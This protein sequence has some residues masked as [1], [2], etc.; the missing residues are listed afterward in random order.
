M[1][2]WRDQLT[3]TAISD[4]WE[5]DTSRGFSVGGSRI[6]INFPVAVYSNGSKGDFVSIE[7]ATVVEINENGSE[8]DIRLN[9]EA[10]V[11]INLS[12]DHDCGPEP[13][14]LHSVSGEIVVW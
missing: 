3:S 12:P 8:I 4:V 9:N 2:T 7:G 13:M 10:H 14:V 5:E 6:T 11:K 1:M